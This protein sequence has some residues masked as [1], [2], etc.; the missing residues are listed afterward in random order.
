MAV[1]NETD[2]NPKF[3]SPPTKFGSSMLQMSPTKPTSEALS[4]PAAKPKSTNE[5]ASAQT[6]FRPN[7]KFYYQLADDDGT[8]NTSRTALF[9]MN[10]LKSQKPTVISLR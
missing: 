2:S 8:S 3:H 5:Q 1:D 10:T 9:H 6:D 7:Y 4:I